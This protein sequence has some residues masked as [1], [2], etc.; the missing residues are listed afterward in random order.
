MPSGRVMVPA[1]EPEALEVLRHSSGHLL[2]QAVKRLLPRLA[3]TNG[4][5]VCPG[6]SPN[7]YPRVFCFVN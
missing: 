1:D 3:M 7:A 5:V 4:N 2:A 6:L